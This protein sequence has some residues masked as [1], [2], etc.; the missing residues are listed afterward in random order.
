MRRLVVTLGVLAVCLGFT[1]A[2]RAKTGCVLTHDRH[3]I[4]GTIVPPG[5]RPP[6]PVRH[7][8]AV[9]KCR[10]GYALVRGVCVVRKPRHVV[11]KCRPGYVRV[12][13]VCVVRRWPAA[14]HRSRMMCRRG[15]VLRGRVCV[16]VR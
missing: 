7:P 5:Y 10:R 2:A 3:V 15:Y 8:R 12:R 13:G 14:V 6:P 1:S 11:V 16:R 9:V 4:C